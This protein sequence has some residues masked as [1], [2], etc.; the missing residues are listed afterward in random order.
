MSRI[1]KH[2]HEDYE[3]SPGQ[4]R[5]DCGAII[6]L[7]RAGADVGCDRCDRSYN[8]SGQLLADRSQWGEETGET[9]F[10][11]DQG[12]AEGQSYSEA[13]IEAYGNE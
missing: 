1:I 9:A 7:W 6:E 13:R 12:F 2:R 4:M 5:C 3:G 10:D 11:Y 8:S